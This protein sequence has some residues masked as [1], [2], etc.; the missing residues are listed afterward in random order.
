MPRASAPFDPSP[1]GKTRNHSA[2]RPTDVLTAAPPEV[3]AAG[4][5]ND[6]AAKNPDG[7]C[8]AVDLSEPNEETKPMEEEVDARELHGEL[9]LLRRPNRLATH[10]RA[11]YREKLAKLNRKAERAA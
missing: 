9:H 11:S 6:L 5:R 4:Q 7:V 1:V 3:T 8:A 2:N 10:A